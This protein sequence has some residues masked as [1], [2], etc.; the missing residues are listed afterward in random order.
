MLGFANYAELSLSTKMAQTPAQVI[1][2][3][4]DLA[5]RARPFALR[6]RAELEAFA[7]KEL[8]M[9]ELDAWDLA[10]VAE[11]L[12]VARY[13]FSDQEVKQYF[14][15]Q[16]VLAG[17]FQVAHTLFDVDVRLASAPVWHPDVRYYEIL[18]AGSVIGSFYLDL[19]AR[20]G[21]RSGAW[22]DD[23]RGRR[24]KDGSVQTPVAYLT[25]N[26]SGP[27]DGKPAL[28]THDEVTTLFHDS[29]GY[30]PPVFLCVLCVTPF[31]S[32]RYGFASR[33]RICAS[34]SHRQCLRLDKDSRSRCGAE[35]LIDAQRG[36]QPYQGE[37][38]RSRCY[39]S[40]C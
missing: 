27:V 28:F 10:Y 6:D 30:K 34:A 15:E 23:A 32:H 35:N 7:R 18:R 4:R 8:G 24:L 5:Q 12:R 20:E 22:M 25:C 39:G 19:Y 2:F 14:P 31:G 13:A 37:R 29:L 9:A 26:F 3:L 33:T 21:K 1:G 17:L 11:K 38:P 36:S 16:K 40:D